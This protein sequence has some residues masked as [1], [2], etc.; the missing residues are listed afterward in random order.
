MF[1][2]AVLLLFLFLP[3]EDLSLNGSVSDILGMRIPDARVVLEHTTDGR[4]WETASTEQ[5]E[6]RF[7]RLSYG[8][9]KITVM[10]PGFVSVLEVQP[11]RTVR[12][13]V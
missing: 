9:Y 3:A 2:Y 13:T 6:F 12:L 10:K 11:F 1:A 5:G 4:R 8:S 7:D